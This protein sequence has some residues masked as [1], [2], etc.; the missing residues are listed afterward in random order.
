MKRRRTE[1]QI[2]AAWVQAGPR[3]LL[4]QS[5]ASLGFALGL[6]L[7][8]GFTR[9]S[10]GGLAQTTREQRVEAGGLH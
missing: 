10:Q 4:I 6:I 9:A 2:A 1:F 5:I 7:T 8:L 3:R